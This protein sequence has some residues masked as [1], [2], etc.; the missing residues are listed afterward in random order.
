MTTGR[1]NQVTTNRP[2]AVEAR[3]RW[4]E[5]NRTK[6]NETTTTSNE[7]G[8]RGTEHTFEWVDWDVAVFT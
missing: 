4:I 5:S 6:A 1:I 3:L 2:P 8:S 7:A